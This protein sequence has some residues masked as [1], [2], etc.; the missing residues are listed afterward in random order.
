M[1]RHKKAV[2]GPLRACPC[3]WCGQKNDL[4]EVNAQYPIEAGVGIECDHC[5]QTATVVTV[6]AEPRIILK[7]KHR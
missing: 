6:D 2:I 4:R 5:H 1:E 7:Q 3:P